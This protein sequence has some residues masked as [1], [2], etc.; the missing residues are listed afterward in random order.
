MGRHR[1]RCFSQVLED[2]RMERK[3]WQE[4]EKEILREDRRV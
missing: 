2:I 4:I 3:S 1:T